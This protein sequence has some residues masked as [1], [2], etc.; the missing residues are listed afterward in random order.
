MRPVP[1][2]AARRSA[3][4]YFQATDPSCGEVVNAR[5]DDSPNA[6]KNPIDDGANDNREDPH[7]GGKRRVEM[8]TERMCQRNQAADGAQNEAQNS[9]DHQ[10]DPER[11]SRRNTLLIENTPGP[12]AEFHSGRD[13]EQ[14]SRA[15]RRG[16]AHH[17]DE[18]YPDQPA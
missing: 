1:A 13:S 18:A 6:A 17:D 4:V 5:A 2:A 7:P 14:G 12:S 9:V 10:T 15:P 11:R 16:N 8:M 3:N